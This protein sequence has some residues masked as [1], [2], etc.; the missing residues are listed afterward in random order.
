M[1]ERVFQSG[2][3]AFVKGGEG[4]PGRPKG[5][6]ARTTMLRMELEDSIDSGTVK[7]VWD[8]IVWRALAGDNEAAKLF[9]HYAVGKPQ[10]KLD[11][12]ITDKRVSE[13]LFLF[14]GPGA[15]DAQGD[16]KAEDMI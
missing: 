12:N 9:M 11:V 5:S 4:G 6:L 8:S 14:S 3:K 1:P 16:G 15:A 13:V 2:E 7:Q 10:G